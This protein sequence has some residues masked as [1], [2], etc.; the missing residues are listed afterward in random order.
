M[1]PNGPTHPVGAS[2]NVL[3]LTLDLQEG[4]QKLVLVLLGGDRVGQLLAIV[5]G[6]QEG[7]EA[8]VLDHRHFGFLPLVA[9][10]DSQVLR[11][12]GSSK[13]LEAF[14][15]ARGVSGSSATIR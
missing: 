8:V 9:R 5:K 15:A 4:W 10:R 13:N 3:L 6:L 11:V 7:L 1:S 14:R 2:G 12:S